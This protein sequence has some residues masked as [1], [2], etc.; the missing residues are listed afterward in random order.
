MNPRSVNLARLFDFGFT[1]IFLSLFPFNFNF[2]AHSDLLIEAARV[3]A[4]WSGPA[5]YP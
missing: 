3:S 1:C 4:G 5:R 2:T